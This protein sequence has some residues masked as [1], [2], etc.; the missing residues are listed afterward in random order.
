MWSTYISRVQTHSHIERNDYNST[1]RSN[2]F[3]IEV[4]YCPTSVQARVLP[5]PTVMLLPCIMQ[6]CFVFL[7]RSSPSPAKPPFTL[8]LIPHPLTYAHA[9]L[10]LKSPPS[11]HCQP[12]EAL[13]R[14]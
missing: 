11:R 9:P 5:A 1:E 8:A 13:C 12:P 10:P 3:G 7:Y 2:E 4:D 14:R 6:F